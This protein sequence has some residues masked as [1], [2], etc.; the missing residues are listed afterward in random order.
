MLTSFYFSELVDTVNQTGTQAE[1]D[2]DTTVVFSLKT[3]LIYLVISCVVIV[4]LYFFY[5]YLG[6]QKETKGDFKKIK[7]RNK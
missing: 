2:Q 5:S 1:S 4:S 3:S 7:E 6:N